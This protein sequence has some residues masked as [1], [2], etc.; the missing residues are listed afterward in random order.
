MKDSGLC[1]DLG[2]KKEIQYEKIDEKKINSMV[3][4]DV[5][6]CTTWL[7]SF[8]YNKSKQQDGFPCLQGNI[9][10]YILFYSFFLL[11]SQ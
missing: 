3:L 1:C 8:K 6:S 9:F 5:L 7:M 10:L 2:D 11:P 4:T